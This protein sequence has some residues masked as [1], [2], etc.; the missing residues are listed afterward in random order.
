MGKITNPYVKWLLGGLVL[1]LLIFLFPPLYGEGYNTITAL[2]AGNSS[3]FVEHSFFY[4]F[5]DNNFIILLFLVLLVVFKVFAS[6]ATNGGG[7]VGGIFAPTLFIGGVTGYFYAHFLQTTGIVNLPVTHFTLV[8]MAAL[9]AGVMHAPLT[10]IFLIAEITN[11]YDLFIPLITV[12]TIAYVT[13]RYFEPH[14]I[15]TKRLAKSGELITH[16]KDKAVLTL[17]KLKDVI[18]TDFLTISPDQTLGE[19]VHVISKSKRNL[20]PVVDSKNRLLGLVLLENIR[21]IMFNRELYNNTEVWQLMVYSPAYIEINER[22]DD[23]MKKFEDTQAWNLPV[24]EDG[25]YIGCV[26][27]SKIFSAYRNVL[28]H[29]SDDEE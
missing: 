6:V 5:R 4:S 19:L 3:S 22:M 29:F 23:V 14:T 15:Y 10:A 16:H 13:N 8:G 26:S 1:S 27:K 21:E 2:L 18:E 24:V 12:S 28:I 11:G 7:G 9:M 25:K 17:M 20:F